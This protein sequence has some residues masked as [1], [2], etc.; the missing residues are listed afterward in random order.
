MVY[1]ALTVEVQELFLLCF[2]RM[3]GQDVIHTV[4]ATMIM[5]GCIDRKT[6]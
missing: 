5:T 3:P 1:N 4:I 6:S 2:V